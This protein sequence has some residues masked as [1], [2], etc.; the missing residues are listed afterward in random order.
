MPEPAE[1]LTSLEKEVAV[2]KATTAHL[3]QAGTDT[4]LRTVETDL[5]AVKAAASVVKW[6]GAVVVALLL[7]AYGYTNFH[8]IPKAASDAATAEATRLTNM[9]LAKRIP[10]LQGVAVQTVDQI[11]QQ[12]TQVDDLV[13]KFKSDANTR[14]GKLQ[15]SSQCVQRTDNGCNP[16]APAA[17]E[18]GWSD[19]GLILSS[20]V[21]GGS[22]GYGPI[23]RVCSMMAPA[24]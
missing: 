9:E 17:C 2:L 18:A 15:L 1:Q 12:K 7:A 6:A 19:T 5:S 24:G 3:A 21:P 23:C 11:M 4:R 8:A 16:P 20:V 10:E 22:C 13:A 14:I